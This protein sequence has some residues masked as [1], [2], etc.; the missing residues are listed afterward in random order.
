[1]LKILPFTILNFFIGDRV[2]ST[3]LLWVFLTILLN[4]PLII[5]DQENL[6][7]KKMLVFPPTPDVVGMIALA[8][9]CSFAIVMISEEFFEVWRYSLDK[10]IT[11]P[12]RRRREQAKKQDPP[13]QIVTLKKS[14]ATKREKF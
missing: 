14:R 6:T 11:M 1:M 5:V 4:L 13:M 12:V 8:A 10:K 9:L 7:D 2:R 3:I